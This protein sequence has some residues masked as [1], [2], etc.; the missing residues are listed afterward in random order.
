MNLEP[1]S[2]SVEENT[3]TRNVPISEISFLD[4]LS[5]PP[6]PRPSSFVEVSHFNFF[7]H[8]SL[9][10]EK[11]LSEDSEQSFD[12]GGAPLPFL[13]QEEFNFSRTSSLCDDQLIREIKSIPQRM[14]FK[15]GDVAD[16]LG[17]K[18][19]VLRYWETEFEMLK[20]KKAQNKQRMYTSKQ[21]EL[22]FLVR[23]LLHRDRYSIE[24]ARNALKGARQSLKQR[25]I[26]MSAESE[27]PSSAALL[28]AESSPIQGRSPQEGGLSFL[29]SGIDSGDSADLERL[30]VDQKILLE[31][32]GRL[33]F[34]L[35]VLRK[36]TQEFR[37]SL[38]SL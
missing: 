4:S 19:F 18:P 25:L 33:R 1:E 38:S 5:Q 15:I 17:V 22:A 21:V 7:S 6:S 2:L 37:Q 28:G 10:P 24:G 34:R 12:E 23:K 31:N 9:E 26:E 36:V 32:L 20:P 3:E 16:L 29:D 27:V 11:A 35:Q 14:F 30:V 13:V 8:S